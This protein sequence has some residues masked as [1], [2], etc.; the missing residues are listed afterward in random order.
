MSM[1]EKIQELEALC[2]KRDK[3]LQ[4]LRTSVLI[5]QLWPEVWDYANGKVSAVWIYET[6][7]LGLPTTLEIS[8]P[9]EARRFSRRQVEKEGG[10]VSDFQDPWADFRMQ[11]VQ[12]ERRSRWKKNSQKESQT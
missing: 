3:L 4:E 2:R 11:H 12:R 9:S 1:L 10:K 6:D 8:I 7:L 5:K